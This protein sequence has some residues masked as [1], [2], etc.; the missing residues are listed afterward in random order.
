MINTNIAH[1]KITAK[2]GQGGMGEVYRATDTKLDRD[3]AIKILPVEI[4]NDPDRRKR[5]IKEAKTASSINHPYVCTIYEVGETDEGQPF[6]AMEF[7]PG[8]TLGDFAHGKPLDDEK[9]VAIG[10]QIADALDA[11]HSAGIVHRDIKPENIHIDSQGRVK[12]LDF[13]LAKIAH[14]RPVSEISTAEMTE[15]G[16]L[17]GTPDYMSPEQARSQDV[18]HRS[19]LFSVGIVLY[20]LT[21]GRLPFSGSGLV[22]TMEKI[23]GTQPEA[24]ARFNYDLSPELERITCKCLEKK[25]EDRYQT[26]K[27]LLI[28]F[29]RLQRQSSSLTSIT[30]EKQRSWWGTWLIA[31][32]IAIA[33]MAVLGSWWSHRSARSETFRFG[34]SVAVLPFQSAEEFHYVSDGLGQE[35]SGRLSQLKGI[36]IPPFSTSDRLTGNDLDFISIANK[37]EVSALLRGNIQRDGQTLQISADLINPHTNFLVWHG[38]YQYDQVKEMPFDIYHEITRSIAQKL[39]IK[40]SGEQEE[41]LMV[42]HTSNARAWK[43]YLEGFHFWERRGSDLWRAK[44]LFELALSFDSPTGHEKDSEFALAWV[45]LADTYTQLATYSM[46]PQGEAYSLAIEHAKR[47]LDLNP[48]LG[49][50]HATLGFSKTW[51]LADLEGALCSFAEA[52][53]LNPRDTRAYYWPTW[54]LLSLGRDADAI[55]MCKEACEIDP[56]SDVALFHL[57]YAYWVSGDAEKAEETARQLT[58]RQPDLWLGHFLLA[59]V[60]LERDRSPEAFEEARKAVDLSDRLPMALRVLGQVYAAIDR[61]HD[62][63]KFLQELTDRSRANKISDDANFVALYVALGDFDKAIEHVHKLVEERSSLLLLHFWPDFRP[64]WQ[65]PRFIKLVNQAGV[66]QYNPETK[67]FDAIVQADHPREGIENP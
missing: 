11:A 60:L 40:L 66:A 22:E 12:V 36:R 39:G 6:I 53:I 34:K 1:Y 52:R 17:M 23:T 19:D 62:T 28:D 50:A 49:D 56:W 44:H 37:L 20:E 27:E 41:A 5:F 38:T 59:R 15:P 13:G 21:T 29:R 30:P 14:T 26:A 32:C 42:A 65:D 18:D 46:M 35:L 4:S 25:P 33:L 63:R 9:I 10:A 16:K 48:F 8:Q 24:M 64:L 57:C 45:G 54:A 51:Y 55:E 3:V 67:R 58:A 31:V 7:L 47:A 61:K 43:A 2:L